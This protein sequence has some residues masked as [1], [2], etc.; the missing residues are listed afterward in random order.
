MTA[1]TSSANPSIPGQPVT[2]TATVSPSVPGAGPPTGT[3][4]FFDNST[5]TDLGNVSLFGGAATLTTSALALGIHDITAS[6]RGDGDFL[7][8]N[9]TL[10]QAVTQSIYILSGTDSG[11][12][13]VSGNASIAIPGSVIIDSSS[14]TAL[15]ASGNAEVASSSTLVVGGVQ[16]SGNAT[17]SPA[18]TT[19]VAPV[20]DP[21][22]NL[23]VPSVSGNA[24]PVNLSGNGALTINPGIYSQ[25][26]VSGSARLTLNP[27]VYVL[28]GGGLTVS[29]NGSVLT[30]SVASPVTGAGVLLYNTESASETYGSITLSGNGTF[31]LTAPTVA[32]YAG[33]VIF[34]DR[35]N[36]RTI[37]LSGN[38][39][40][41]GSGNTLYASA[42]LLLL[43]GNAD[44]Q[45][46]LV[47][48]E[49]ALSGNADPSEVMRGTVPTEQV[50]PPEGDL[51]VVE[52]EAD[53]SGQ[54]AAEVNPRPPGGTGQELQAGASRLGATA[55]DV[56]FA[57]M[58][59]DALQPGNGGRTADALNTAAPAAAV[60]LFPA[61]MP[62]GS[63]VGA[64]APSL[65]EHSS[66]TML[67]LQLLR[68]DDVA[69]AADSIVVPEADSGTTRSGRAGVLITT[70][71]R[72]A[73]PS[74]LELN[75]KSNDGGAK[76][77]PAAGN[78][79]QSAGRTQQ[80]AAGRGNTDLLPE[81]VAA[82]ALFMLIPRPFESRIDERK[83][84][85]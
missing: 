72:E 41:E 66:Q 60:V 51:V 8:S 81:L 11:A 71:V 55:R 20:S 28:A 78:N 25:I 24:S 79:S 35:A 33:V 56:L 16:K 22:L 47:V 7:A 75:R 32:P 31:N 6:Y 18:P 67:G 1:V 4:V 45:G 65:K 58:A 14:K 42:A 2:F 34:Q 19:G 48:S 12:L 21:L 59:A 63:D 69:V 74:R 17:L 29:G 64:P 30:G 3:V 9:S 26:S 62:P 10:T 73:T 76:R 13:S 5:G 82:F 83:K 49:L 85:L 61:R 23:P 80:E 39:L 27:G 77:T 50:S 68:T 36:A 46:A 15:S 54:I 44:I 38:A 40:M 52:V 84:S 53:P 37:A 57:A 43:S 70:D